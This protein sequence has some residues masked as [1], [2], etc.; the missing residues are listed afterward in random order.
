M[1][2]L[3]LVFISGFQLYNRTLDNQ[4]RNYSAPGIAGIEFQID[5]ER[6][7]PFIRR[8]PNDDPDEGPSSPRGFNNPNI[9]FSVKFKNKVK[10]NNYEFIVT[11]EPEGGEKILKQYK[12]KRVLYEFQDLFNYLESENP[13]D[14]YLRELD[15]NKM[16]N[17]GDNIQQLEEFLNRL[18]FTPNLF[19]GSQKTYLLDKRVQEFL[20][21]E[22]PQILKKLVLMSLSQNQE[23][24][25]KVYTK[26]NIIDEYRNKKNE[27]PQTVYDSFSVKVVDHGVNTTK[28]EL[29][30]KNNFWIISKSQDLV[31]QYLDSINTKLLS[32]LNVEKQNP[33]FST[34]LFFDFFKKTDQYSQ[35]DVFRTL[36]LQLLNIDVRDADLTI[37]PQGKTIINIALEI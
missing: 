17:G 6:G 8:R 13:Q 27:S 37:D 7:L 11:V 36:D 4:K 22:D 28:F 33:R 24:V 5:E 9:K 34:L 10:N 23:P 2:L 14:T 12:V 25:S 29:S 1:M 15:Y 35:I 16:F 26:L 21:I 3:S 31:D 20:Q 19:G 32:S 30:F 18:I